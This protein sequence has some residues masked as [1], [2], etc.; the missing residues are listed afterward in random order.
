MRSSAHYCLL[1][2]AIIV[3]TLVGGC[4][5]VQNSR[6]DADN[7]AKQAWMSPTSSEQADQLRHRLI[8]GQADH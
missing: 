6:T 7:V 3:A 2:G 1:A 8:I 5:G 4:G